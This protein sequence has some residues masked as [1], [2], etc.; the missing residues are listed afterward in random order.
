MPIIRVA[1][2]SHPYVQIDTTCLND[3]R[4]SLRAK[5]LHAYL[6]SK[7]DGWKVIMAHLHHSCTEGRDAVSRAMQELYQTGYASRHILRGEDGKL[8]GWETLVYESPETPTTV[9]LKNR[10]TEKPID[11]K[12][13]NGKPGN[14]FSGSIVI[15]E[16]VILEEVR[17]ENP[18]KETTV[19]PISRLGEQ[20]GH[21]QDSETLTLIS[22]VQLSQKPIESSLP[23]WPSPEAL[24][25]LYNTCVPVDH[26]HVRLP[27]S[28]KRKEKA[29]RILHAFPEEAWWRACFSEVELSP[30]LRSG[31]ETYPNFRGDFDWFLSNGQNG[32]E[33]CVKT[34]EGK[35]RPRE[36]TSAVQADDMTQ[37]VLARQK[38]RT[39]AYRRAKT[40]GEPENPG[41]VSGV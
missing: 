19:S 23:L 33:N 22:D 20:S 35:Y 40:P 4:L 32:I 18:Q 14:G 5:G 13:G 41:D 3:S 17:K 24:A 7:P 12:P 25:T 10:V 8:K 39:D 28:P 36:R 1:K 30:L 11:G 2:R 26:R 37:R 29:R 27:L 16:E 6:M 21:C 38:E 9:I 15:K 31:S 34:F